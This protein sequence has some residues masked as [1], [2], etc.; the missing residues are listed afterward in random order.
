MGNKMLFRKSPQRRCA[1]VVLQALVLTNGVGQKTQQQRF[2][3]L[4]IS[5][6]WGKGLKIKPVPPLPNH[7]I[8][9]SPNHFFA[10]ARITFNA[11]PALNHS[12]CWAL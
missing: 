3:L 2:E 1:S 7:Q 9:K 8:I 5:K 4:G 6:K 11:P 12:I 10:S